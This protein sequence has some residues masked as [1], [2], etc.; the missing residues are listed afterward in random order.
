MGLAAAGFDL[1]G[2]GFI[3]IAFGTGKI[4]IAPEAS[5]PV[6]SAQCDRLSDRKSCSIGNKQ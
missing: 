6:Q 2:L 3:K 5:K 4:R 1:L